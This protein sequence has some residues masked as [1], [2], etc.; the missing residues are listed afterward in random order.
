MVGFQRFFFLN[1]LKF[2]GEINLTVSILLNNTISEL[3]KIQ[4]V[5]E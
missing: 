3:S 2:Y 1:N 4:N 5:K